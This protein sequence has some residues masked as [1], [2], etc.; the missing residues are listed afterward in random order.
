[1]VV[2]AGG[3]GIDI[4]GA[5]TM[6]AG[7]VI[8]NGPTDNSN[9]ALDFS[10]FKMTGGYLVAVGSSGMAQALSTTSTQYSVLVN[11][12]SASSAGTLIHIETS[13]GDDVVTFKAAKQFQSIVV[14]SASLQKGA[15]YDVYLGGSSTG[16]LQDGV[17]TGG[18]Y[19]AGTKY[20]SFTINSIVTTVR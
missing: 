18:V 16:T 14:C 20:T 2:D 10:S 7:T 8:V 19:T 3:D 6:T 13:N 1:V 5:V 17:Y 9:G 11:F 4:N 12:R 15:T